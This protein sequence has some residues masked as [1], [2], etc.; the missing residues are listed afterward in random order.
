MKLK[1]SFKRSKSLN[2]LSRL[3]VAGPALLAVGISAAMAADKEPSALNLSVGGFFYTGMAY[4]DRNDD[5]TRNAMSQDAEIYFNAHGVLDN[6]ISV[7][8]QVQLEAQDENNDPIDETYVYIDGAYG[9]LTIG[10]EN[11]ATYLGAVQAPKFVAGFRP[12]DNNLTDS[13][14]ER[15]L[16]LRNDNDDGFAVGPNGLTYSIDDPNMSTLSEQISGDELK[17]IYFTPRYYGLRAGVSYSANNRNRSGGRDNVTKVSDQDDIYSYAVD[18]AHAFNEDTILKVSLGVTEGDN[19]MTAP[20]VTM[21][22]QDPKITSIGAALKV[23]DVSVG[24]NFTNYKNHKGISGQDIKTYNVAVKYDLGR[25]S[26]GISFTDSSDDGI[27]QVRS[28]VDYTEWVVGGQTRLAPGVA[29][30]YFYQDA[31]ADYS[32]NLARDVSLVGLTLALK[33]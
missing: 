4:V 22:Y 23:K 15:N 33:I 14:L 18:Y 7:G 25:T 31:E 21:V 12:Y 28:A 11:D 5:Y 19:A 20:S 30:G 3:L 24:G 6:G 27:A 17:I 13:I 26:L 9:R 29:V 16:S 2:S 32:N 1:Q 8:L 10:S